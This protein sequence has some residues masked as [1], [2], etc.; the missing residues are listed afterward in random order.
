EEKARGISIDLG[1]A[2]VDTPAGTCIGFVDVPG[3]ER[4][5]RNM[6]AGVCGI[7]AVLLVV[8]ADDGVMPQ[9][10]EHLA[11][12][13]LL[14]IK[15]GL[16][17]ISKVDCESS[18]RV[19]G[20]R[21]EV[22][23]LLE[24]TGLVG[25]EIVETS[26]VTGA[27]IDELRSRLYA[28]ADER[29]VADQQ[30][31]RFRYAIDRA[32]SV[33][34]SGTVV[35]GTVFQGS[36]ARG[37]RLKLA[38]SGVEVRVR[39]IQKAHL[40][41]ETAQA[42]ERCAL[43]LAGVE[44]HHATRGQ[45]VVADDATTTRLDVRL[46]VLAD[47]PSLGHWASVHLH[48]GTS[49]VNA[50]IAMIGG[51]ALASGSSAIVQ[52]LCEAPMSAVVGDRF[53]IRDPSARRTLGGGFVVDPFPPRRNVSRAV[54]AAQ[55][56]AM[57]TLSPQR[58]LPVLLSVSAGGVDLA[59][60]GRAFNLEPAYRDQIARESGAQIVGEDPPRAL[61]GDGAEEIKN[62]I[63]V[64]LARFHSDSPQAKGL[65]LKALR[66][67]V[68]RALSADTFAALVR[69]FAVE[70]SVEIVG[71][72]V[73]QIGHVATAN[74]ADE[75]LWQRVKPVLLEAGA[76]G[77]VLSELAADLRIHE[78]LLADFLHR[79]S[80]THD[81]VRVTPERFY[82][83]EVLAQLAAFATELAARAPDQS[84][85]A[86]RFRDGAGVNRT[87]AI[88]ILECFDR[89]GITQRVGD[90]RKIRGDFAPILGPG[91]APGRPEAE[92]RSPPAPAARSR[93]RVERR[94]HSR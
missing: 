80:A 71:S 11:I 67:L 14:G 90:A 84:F 42:G 70:L 17:T 93:E 41:V 20:L 69:R 22:A 39:G 32:F 31:R 65:E 87:L 47:A 13:D 66:A 10:R 53:I 75:V 59:L 21:H 19:L 25:A 77:Q 48:I 6:I 78:S 74:R 12:V 28:A 43:N 73:C 36:V 52:L 51:G 89:I 83:R 82:P 86:A 5:V 1:F 23:A 72:M 88:Q 56:D 37:D 57:E 91:R 45:W 61:P 60:F 63:V 58:A 4:F 24:G 3:H 68:A 76:R 46:R 2:Y 38:P 94:T 9:T 7:D 54:R 15:R 55:L 49:D 44:R 85:I 33:A 35:T 16:V 64:A 81:V 40:A 92:V 79:K 8:A 27:G 26:V 34:G 30:Q 50:R 62:A 18:A 29:A